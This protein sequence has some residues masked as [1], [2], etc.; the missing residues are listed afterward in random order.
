M[1]STLFC[2]FLCRCFA[3]L[4]RETS[5]SFLGGNVVR[6]LVH[7]FFTAAHSH[8]LFCHAMYSSWYL[9]VSR[10]WLFRSLHNCCLVAYFYLLFNII[11]LFV[12]FMLTCL[13]LFVDTDIALILVV[14]VVVVLY[15]L[16][17]HVLSV[18]L[19]SVIV[20]KPFY[21][22]CQNWTHLRWLDWIF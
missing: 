7:F 3:R 5:R 4:Q 2:T 1:W 18:N 22:I 8:P 19:A 14:A 10:L 9:E 16:S 11:C 12:Y 21:D 20:T 13:H 6:V 17:T 15:L